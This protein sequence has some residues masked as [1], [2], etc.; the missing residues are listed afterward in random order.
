MNLFKKYGTEGL[1]STEI[2]V[3]QNP[4]QNLSLYLKL[5]RRNFLVCLM[6]SRAENISEKTSLSYLITGQK[7][8]QWFARKFPNC[9]QRSKVQIFNCRGHCEANDLHLLCA[10]HAKF[11]EAR[12]N[13]WVHSRLELGNDREYDIPRGKLEAGNV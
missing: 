1:W 5:N 12:P 10:V 7:W 8:K 3:K 13:N 11:T 9:Q 4:A 6:F 2:T